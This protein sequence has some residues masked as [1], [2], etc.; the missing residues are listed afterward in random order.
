MSQKSQGFANVV[1][2]SPPSPFYCAGSPEYFSPDDG[3][4]LDVAKINVDAKMPVVVTSRPM[5]DARLCNW[6]NGPAR[7]RKS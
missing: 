6:R 4:V 5:R 7:L 1:G 2:P 3:F